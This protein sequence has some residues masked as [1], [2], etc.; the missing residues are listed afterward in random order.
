MSLRSRIE[1]LEQCLPRQKQPRRIIYTV[2]G[3]ALSLTSSTCRRSV[4]ANGCLKEFVYL[5]GS[6]A[7]LTDAQFEQF[8][9]SFPIEH[10]RRSG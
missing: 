3:P 4:D 5:F 9:S 2:V 7:G 1:R 8:I 6:R 10:T